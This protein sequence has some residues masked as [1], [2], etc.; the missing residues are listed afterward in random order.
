MT[1]Y[2]EDSDTYRD[3]GVHIDWMDGINFYILSSWAGYSSQDSEDVYNLLK[4]I[5]RI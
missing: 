2:I 3:L 1:V 5:K 4:H